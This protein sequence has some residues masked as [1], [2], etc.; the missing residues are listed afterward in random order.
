MSFGTKEEKELRIKKYKPRVN[1][2]GSCG[3]Q[4]GETELLCADCRND[5]T[6]EGYEPLTQME[7][8]LR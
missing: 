3:E 4:V 2:C 6:P 8:R 5:A 7:R 1:L